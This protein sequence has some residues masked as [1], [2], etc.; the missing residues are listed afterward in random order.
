MPPYSKADAAGEEYKIYIAMKSVRYGVEVV[1]MRLQFQTSH[2][3]LLEL[4]M[5]A[6]TAGE[7]QNNLKIFEK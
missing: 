1:E 2:V 7:K 5:A 3:K 6:N 4:N